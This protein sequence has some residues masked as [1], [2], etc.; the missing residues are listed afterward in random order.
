MSYGEPNFSDLSREIKYLIARACSPLDLVNFSQLDAECRDIVLSKNLFRYSILQLGGPA[1]E[2]MFLSP[3]L[4]TFLFTETACWTCGKSTDRYPLSFSLRIRVCNDQCKTILFKNSSSS[5][6][7]DK[8]ST[9]PSRA[10]RAG[11]AIHLEHIQPWAPYL[12]SSTKDKKIYSTQQL[13]CA[14]ALFSAA[15][16]ADNAEAEGLSCAA[17]D[18]LLEQW[19]R[20]RTELSA[21]MDGSNRLLA[22]RSSYEKGR[23]RYSALNDKS[24]KDMTSSWKVGKGY[25]LRS[26]TLLRTLEWYSKDHDTFTIDAFERIS[27]VVYSEARDLEYRRPVL[28]ASHGKPPNKLP[29]RFCDR[30][31][32]SRVYSPSDLL[33]HIHKRH[34]EEFTKAREEYR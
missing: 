12:E 28:H 18:L 11:D 17:K 25:I 24:V 19:A 2:R 23:R 4:I 1:L 6:D 33:Q 32:A 14:I 8:F 31:R 3:S 13:S 29:C 21:L 20:R 26:P 30:K 15:V 27:G 9:I 34:S 22:W 16:G 5:G 10:E 7:P